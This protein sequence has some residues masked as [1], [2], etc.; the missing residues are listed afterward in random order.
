M[1]TTLEKKFRVCLKLILNTTKMSQQL[2]AYML[3]I[4]QFT[5]QSALSFK[6]IIETLRHERKIEKSS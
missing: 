4:S 1:I 6:K 3:D 2:K 5:S